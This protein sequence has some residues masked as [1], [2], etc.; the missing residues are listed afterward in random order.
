MSVID[1]FLNRTR[2][3]ADLPILFF[4]GGICIGLIADVFRVIYHDIYFVGQMI[5][6]AMFFCAVIFSTV[7]GILLCKDFFEQRQELDYLIIL[8]NFS[9]I[10]ILLTIILW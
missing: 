9:P 4:F 7:N 5:R 1:R 10:I 6:I 8:I 2:E 3:N